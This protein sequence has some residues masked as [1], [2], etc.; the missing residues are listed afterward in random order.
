MSEPIKQCDYFGCDK[1]QAPNQ[2]DAG[3]RFCTEHDSEF[4]AIA[5]AEPFDPKA[6]MQFWVQANGGA[7]RLADL[8]VGDVL[9]DLGAEQ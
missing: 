7:E 9:R 2:A 4:T 1:P 5:K 3:M 8:I 6:M